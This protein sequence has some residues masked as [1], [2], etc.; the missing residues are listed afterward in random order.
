MPVLVM[1][2]IWVLSVVAVAEPVAAQASACRPEGRLMPLA[3]LPEASGIVA[4]R[5]TQG[6][7]WLHND[8]GAPVLFAFDHDGKSAGRL[9]VT[10][11]RVE[12]WEA[13]AIGPCGSGSSIR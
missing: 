11:A 12:D 8:S 1:V 10:G 2:L 13:L 9:M 5:I 6:R 7:V 3:E 4:S